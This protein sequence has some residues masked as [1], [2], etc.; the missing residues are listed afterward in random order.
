[1]IC[2]QVLTC[3]CPAHSIYCVRDWVGSVACQADLKQAEPLRGGPVY[4]GGCAATRWSM[5]SIKEKK[6]IPKTKS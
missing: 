3:L 5:A 4:K 2:L 1:M 6:E